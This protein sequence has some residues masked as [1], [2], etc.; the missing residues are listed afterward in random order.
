MAVTEAVV[1]DTVVAEVDKQ[2]VG[3]DCGVVAP[4][5]CLGSIR[6]KPSP[7]YVSNARS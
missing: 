3:V 5:G 6:Q 4:L 7:S 2:Q 1:A